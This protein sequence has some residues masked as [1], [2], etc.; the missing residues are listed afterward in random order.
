MKSHA[1]KS[2]NRLK[3]L[4]VIFGAPSLVLMLMLIFILNIW[5]LSDATMG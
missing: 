3:N 4:C 5:I 1:Q 2:T